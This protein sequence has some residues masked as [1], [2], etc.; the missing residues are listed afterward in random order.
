MAWVYERFGWRDP[1]YYMSVNSATI[2]YSRPEDYGQNLDKILSTWMSYSVDKP[3]HRRLILKDTLEKFSKRDYQ[4]IAQRNLDGWKE[5]TAGEPKKKIIIIENMD[6]GD[7]TLKYTK[8]YGTTFACLKM[9]NP[10]SYP[11]GTYNLGG[12]GQEENMFRR[13]DCHFRISRL[14]LERAGPENSNYW[15]YWKYNQEQTDYINGMGGAG[16]D[17]VYLSTDTKHP[18]ICIKGAE[19]FSTTLGYELLDDEDI[20]PFYELR[21]APIDRRFPYLPP[22]RVMSDDKIAMQTRIKAQFNT[23]KERHVKHVILGA[24]GCGSFRNNPLT[25]ANLYIEAIQSNIEH[26][27]AIVFAIPCSTNPFPN[28]PNNIYAAFDSVFRAR[29]I[30]LTKNKILPDNRTDSQIAEEIAEEFLM[31]AR[32]RIIELKNILKLRPNAKVTIS[33]NPNDAS[34]HNL[35]TSQRTVEAW[36]KYYETNYDVTQSIPHSINLALKKFQ[37]G[38]AALFENLRSEFN[39]GNSSSRVSYGTLDRRLASLDHYLV[40][41]AYTDTYESTL[42]RVKRSESFSGGQQAAELSPHT[43]GL[44]G[45][46]TTPGSPPVSL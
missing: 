26:F 19:T 15:K 28:N 6:W 17:Q 39:D 32:D 5:A 9:T 37:Y 41:G 38:L 1:D 42:E 3:T 8:L 10:Y 12:S 4:E 44:F 11:G 2:R 27:E 14:N 22:K 40:W 43:I 36:N 34:K 30:D 31:L 13:T 29:P 20:F 33:A 18:R 24:F 25:I 35:A 23:L 21:C 46:I 16:H 45:I 7:A